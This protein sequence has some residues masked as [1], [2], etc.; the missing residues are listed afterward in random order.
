MF[1]GDR[2][3]APIEKGLLNHR[4]REGTPIIISSIIGTPPNFMNSL[5]WTIEVQQLIE[6]M[7]TDYR[8]E[9]PQAFEIAGQEIATTSTNNNRALIEHYLGCSRPML[10]TLGLIG[11]KHR[12]ELASLIAFA[13]NFQC[14]DAAFIYYVKQ[15]S[16]SKK[17]SQLH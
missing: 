6:R 9:F 4:Q 15:K 11:F 17:S 16:Q 8:R 14:D 5:I 13:C 2:F 7:S 10:G 3:F 12:S 1:I